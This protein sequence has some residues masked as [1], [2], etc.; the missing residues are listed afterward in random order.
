VLLHPE[1]WPVSRTPIRSWRR[2]TR[3]PVD[4]DDHLAARS[5]AE[6]SSRLPAAAA[7]WATLMPIIVTI[8]VIRTKLKRGR[9][10]GCG[11]RREACRRVRRLDRQARPVQAHDDL[12]P[13]LAPPWAGST[14]I[15]LRGWWGRQ[16]RDRP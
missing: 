7:N 14:S 9:F 13:H 6:L 4:R 11:R 12:A 2:S 5:S 10:R 8:A 1:V 3:N 16:T 15:D